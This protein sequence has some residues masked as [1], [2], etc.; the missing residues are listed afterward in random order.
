[1]YLQDNEWVKILAFLQTCPG[2]Y[3][4][5]EAACRRFLNGALWVLRSGA[6][7]R[8]LPER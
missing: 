3:V 4:G 6:K 1:V 5:N 8:L 7:W 2:I